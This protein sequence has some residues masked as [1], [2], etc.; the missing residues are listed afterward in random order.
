MN[1]LLL[2]SREPSPTGHG[3]F[4]RAYQTLQDAQANWPQANFICIKRSDLETHPPRQGAGYAWQ[5]YQTEALDRLRLSFEFLRQQASPYRLF[6]FLWNLYARRNTLQSA[7]RFNQAAY[8]DILNRQ[9]IDLCLLDHTLFLEAAQINQERKIPTWALPQ[10]LETFDR[11][12]LADYREKNL[13]AF[14]MG[15]RQELQLFQLSQKRLLI[16]RAEQWLLNGL[17]MEAEFY[18][19]RPT[20]SLRQ[21]LLAIRARRAQGE[22]QPGL[23]LLLGT[24]EHTTTG[25]G[26]NWLL[27]YASQQG[28]PAGSRLAVVGKKTET[29][30]ASFASYPN[31][32]F[33]GWV[34]DETLDNFLAQA[35]AA[36]IPQMCGFG[37]VT[38]IAEFTCAGLP[39][40]VS[41]HASQAQPMPP[42]V[43]CLPPRWSDWEE[44]LQ[45]A[46]QHFSPET[47]SLADWLGWEKQLPRLPNQ[48]GE[49]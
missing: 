46:R 22:V 37:A 6:Q 32:T 2:F 4:H 13:P 20:G 15:F 8:K 44:A 3:G 28:L 34:S 7:S 47:P 41:E 49:L 12:A 48:V 25:Q 26:F 1:I 21:R 11:F 43:L 29:L 30:A 36:L 17:D 19:Y 38:R 33:H 35:Q 10:N 45:Q 14:L 39:C 5:E 23:F 9:P 40:L 42:G 16:S 24:S 18:P 31:I 27:R